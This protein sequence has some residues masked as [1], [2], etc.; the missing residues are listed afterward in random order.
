M[1]HAQKK[2][3]KMLLGKML[4]NTEHPLS[5]LDEFKEYFPDH[6]PSVVKNLFVVSGSIFSA[7]TPNLWKA[8]DKG[9][10]F[11][12]NHSGKPESD[13]Q[14]LLRFFKEE[15][16]ELLIRTILS[17]VLFSIGSLRR[18][19]YL[20]LDGTSWEYG[21]KK[22]HLL[23]L[24]VVHNG[25]SIPIWWTD[26]DKKGV[27]NQQE[28]IALF[29][30]ALKSDHLQKKL[31]L[32]DR[33][34]IGSDW[35]HF[36]KKEKIEFIIRVPRGRYKNNVNRSPLGK[37]KRQHQKLWYDALEQRA[38]QPKYAACGVNKEIRLGKEKYW[39]TVWKNPKEENKN[40][41]LFYFISSVKNKRK[42][43]KAYRIRWTIEDCF[44]H[45][46]TNGFH[47][48]E[49]NFKKSSKIELLMAILVLIYTLT[50]EKGWM[51][52]AA[53]TRKNNKTYTDESTYS[54]AS[55][56]RKGLPYLE[57]VAVN[58]WIFWGFVKKII[59]ERK[60]PSWVKVKGVITPL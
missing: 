34:Y 45:L 26:L 18:H 3:E 28:R 2:S 39:F 54:Y 9:S 46:K 29:K 55:V 47:L 1:K 13:Y 21:S 11:L 6:R 33:E 5:L 23:T 56:F 10:N 52:E 51:A 48:E 40:E 7:R 15:N 24:S 27:S 16:G 37:G 36:L 8:K 19:R 31:L 57:R 58:I 50:M 4:H 42:V 38:L 44:Y 22:I 25:V 59:K 20:V 41:P 43:I 49:M 32:A 17:V 53:Q 14:R 60:T 30:A 35:L 12:E